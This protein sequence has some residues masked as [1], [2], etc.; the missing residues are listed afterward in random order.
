[1]QGQKQ[2]IR[3]CMALMFLAGALMSVMVPAWQTPDER[4]HVALMG[5]AV[6][7]PQLPE[8]LEQDMN[9]GCDRIRFQSEEKIDLAQ[10]K[11]AMG[12]EPGYSRRDC[13]PQELHV[14]AIKHLPALVGLLLGVFLRLPTFWAMA[15]AELCSLA[16]YLAICRWVL[17]LMPAK[18]GLLLMVMAL[19]MTLQQA[20]SI[21]YDAVL[22]PLCFLY[23]AYIFHMRCQKKE[24]GWLDL[25]LTAL[26]LL[27]IAYIKLPYAPLGLM[28]FLLPLKKVCLRIGKLEVNGA[29]LHRFRA[30]LAIALILLAAAALYAVRENFWVRLIGGML[31]EWKGT[32]HLFAETAGTYWQFLITSSVGQFGWLD[33]NLPFWFA[34]ATYG[35]LLLLAVWG[36]E[37]R[38]ANW[39]GGRAKACLWVAFLLLTCLTALSM[40]NHTVKMMLF[41][42]EQAD[43]EYQI[44]EAIYQ[45]PYIGGLQGRYF[46]PFLALP[47]LGL[48][49]GGKERAGQIWLVAGYL[50]VA[51]MLTAY[52]LY[53]RYWG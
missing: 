51:T 21:S 22:L 47:F 35:L 43:A 26:L 2:A 13:M 30:L 7:N 40:V 5:E 24:I 44:R 3:A 49:Q 15:L 38:I 32:A 29:T 6:G 41:G 12:K 20:S 36:R 8:L 16:F 42:S 10:W 37:A 4:A 25:I 50:L 31:L 11:A 45:I 23:V 33:S 19:P 46:L 28:V 48:P 9:L 53:G 39:P 18:K 17:A 52:V 34:I 14:S 1:M 27:L